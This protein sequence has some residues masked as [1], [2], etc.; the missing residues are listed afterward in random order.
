MDLEQL[1]T[2]FLWTIPFAATVVLSLILLHLSRKDRDKRKIMLMLSFAF[3]SIGYFNLML[4]RFGVAA[5]LD[6]NY[7]WSF[8]PITAALL[9]ATISSLLKLRKFDKPF[10]CFLLTLSA[11]IVFL[12]FPAAAEIIRVP[13]L[14]AFGTL[15][16]PALVYLVIKR[17]NNSD[18]MFLLAFSCFMFSGISLDAGLAEETTVLLALFGVV[19]TALMFTISNDRT[20]GDM[21]S[22][23]VLQSELQKAQEDLKLTQEQAHRELEASE[24]RF[25][26]ICEDARVVMLRLNRK[27]RVTYVNRIV[28]E[29]G[30]NKDE[31]I[32]KSMLKFVPKKYKLR[33]FNEHLRVLRGNN[34]EGEAEI[35]TPK[36][37]LTVDY[38]SNPVRQDG[39]VVECET[40]LRDI[41]EKKEMEKK[42]Q[43]YAS[44]LESM[45]EAR[46]IALKKSEEKLVRYSKR[47]EELVEERTKQ[48][49]QAERMATIGELAGMIGHDL[50][51]PLTAIAGAAY[52]LKTKEQSISEKEKDMLATIENA[53]DNSNR[54]IGDLLEY[55][56]EIKLNR[57]E[58]DPKSLLEE[59]LAH[60]EVPT[61]I[62][63]ANKTKSE[64][65]A[66]IDKDKMQRVF[67]NLIKNA[68]DAMPNGGVLTIK[69]KKTQNDVS[70]SFIDTGTGMSEETLQKIWTPLF[71]TKAKGMGFGLPICRRLIEAHNGK[72]RVES[73]IG[74]GTTFIITI[75]IEYEREKN[76][77]VLVNLPEAVHITKRE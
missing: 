34:V 17:R 56:R 51:N 13:L 58:T 38:A 26:T 59:T 20:A 16:F 33:I 10:E 3:A 39:K 21:A 7:K 47:L 61:G 25:R 30:I 46:T 43:A 12:V 6:I 15:A 24:E 32:G 11:S 44:Q 71:T 65:R 53:V 31:I 29:Y 55:S 9:I 76:E 63:V 23:F 40:V 19:F 54:I 22:F 48:L 45:V 52:Y 28:S 60:L 42:L 66:K 36:G 14:G 72:I 62:T 50:R 8:I 5:P 64:P 70:F 35:I 73:Q 57:S 69:S 2:A 68:F 27:G 67:I 74:K 18:L 37:K 49:R 4:E 75:P 41:T 77:D 1:S